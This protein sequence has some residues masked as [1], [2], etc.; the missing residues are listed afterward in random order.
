[1]HGEDPRGIFRDSGLGHYLARIDAMDRL[2]RFDKLGASFEAF[3]IEEVL[4]GMQSV[5]LGRWN[6]SYYRTKNGA[7]IDL[8]LDGSFGLLPIEIKLGSHTTLR[9]LNALRRFVVAH[10]LE[11]GIVINNSDEVR[12]LCKEVL[13]VPAGCL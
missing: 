3:V 10:G 4:K 5:Q 9:Q 8:I 1:M 13:Q 11:A 7:E 12:W 6:Y 2:L